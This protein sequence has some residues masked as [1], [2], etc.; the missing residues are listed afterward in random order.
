MG[1]IVLSSSFTRPADTTAYASGDL[2]AN[3]TTA[4]LVT[5]MSFDLSPYQRPFGM[6]GMVRRVRIS[7]TGTT[8]T[9]AAF[10]AHLYTASPT[11]ANGDNAAWSTN[12]ATNYLGYLNVSSMTAFTDGC[13]GRGAPA[14]GTEINFN[15]TMLDS[16]ALYCLLEARGAYTPASAEVFTVRLELVV[17]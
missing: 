16:T 2:V 3:S 7:K 14:N 6:A 5:P 11:P 4:A 9:N 8:A 13:N 1:T 15:A 17:D 10:Y 12:K